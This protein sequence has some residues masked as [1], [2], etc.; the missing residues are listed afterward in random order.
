MISI[1]KRI[2]SDKAAVGSVETILLIALAVFAVLA[3]M[4]FVIGPIRNSAEG[5][6]GEIEKM[7]PRYTGN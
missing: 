1:T 6:G 5:I 7:D 3:I 4:K 2:K